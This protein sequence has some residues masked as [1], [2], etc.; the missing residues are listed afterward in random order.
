MSPNVFSCNPAWLEKLKAEQSKLVVTTWSE[1]GR[2]INNA[3][4]EKLEKLEAEGTA[5]F[6]CD[7]S[8][9]AIIDKL[10]TK[11]DGETIVFKHG[12]ESG[13]LTPGDDLDKNLSEV[14]EMVR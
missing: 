3:W 6:V 9:K 5:V 2:S 12:V 1:N 4:L 10:G 14:R 8:C 7:E 13:R 11:T